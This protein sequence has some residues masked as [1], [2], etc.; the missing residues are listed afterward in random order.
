MKV[1]SSVPGEGLESKYVSSIMSALAVATDDPS[2]A[3]PVTRPHLRD[4][5][6]G[7]APAHPQGPK[8]WNAFD[9]GG[10]TVF[11][12]EMAGRETM[13]VFDHGP[14][15]YLSIAAH[16]HADA[17]SVWLHVDGQPVLIDAGT[18]LYHSGGAMRDYFRGTSAHNTLTLNDKNQSRISGA[19]NWSHKA[20]SWRLPMRD[21]GGGLCSV[22]RHDGYKK[23]FGL[24]HERRV[25][26]S[27]PDGYLITDRLIGKLKSP[28]PIA[29]VR[30][31]LSPDLDVTQPEQNRVE[32]AI[33]GAP[34]VS[35]VFSFEQDDAPCPVRIEEADI[36]PQFGVKI[37][38]KYLVVYFSTA[39]L[40]STTSLCA[41]FTFYN[42]FGKIGNQQNV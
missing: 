17:L 3:A 2:L 9:A 8:G 33:D 21:T 6:L 19:F 28:V 40:G 26:L 24:V 32:L 14:L 18:Y 29:R 42:K 37:D 12:Q 5:F 15:G 27:V 41:L 39:E 11:R 23:R 4:L 25:A 22:A 35:I 31:F 38:G 34:L 10:Y 13:L 16:G 1:A 20:K 36:S 30:Y 7:A